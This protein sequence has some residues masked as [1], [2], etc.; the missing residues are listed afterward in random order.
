MVSENSERPDMYISVEGSSF[1]VTS[2]GKVLV[3]LTPNSRPRSAHRAIRRSNMGTAS[4][5][6]RSSRKCVSSKTM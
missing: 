2:T 1:L 5:H 3:S 4:T 6:C